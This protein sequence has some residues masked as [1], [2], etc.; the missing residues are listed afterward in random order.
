LDFAIPDE[1]CQVAGVSVS[2]P[3]LL[4]ADPSALNAFGKTSLYSAKPAGICALATALL[5]SL[6]LDVRLVLDTRSGISLET[7]HHDVDVVRACAPTTHV[8]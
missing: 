6:T 2:Y 3:T 8:P 5:S 4:D 7:S 1:R